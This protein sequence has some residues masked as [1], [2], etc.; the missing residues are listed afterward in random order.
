MGAVW[1]R[2]TMIEQLSPIL[3]ENT[4]L[5]SQSHPSRPPRLH[6]LRLNSTDNSHWR[7][8]ASRQAPVRLSSHRVTLRWVRSV[9]RRIPKVMATRRNPTLL[10]L[11]DQAS[12]N[13]SRKTETIPTPSFIPQRRSRNGSFGCRGTSWDCVKRR[14]RRMLQPEWSR[15][16]GMLS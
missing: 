1:A 11:A 7:Q 12:N 4:L 10:F 9:S 14:S 2:T 15:H 5:E 13:D 6:R 16:I 8:T 3:R